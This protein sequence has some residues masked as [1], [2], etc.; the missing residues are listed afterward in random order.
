MSDAYDQLDTCNLPKSYNAKYG[1]NFVFYI[2]KTLWETIDQSKEVVVQ[3]FRQILPNLMKDRKVIAYGKC[4]RTSIC[5]LYRQITATVRPSR[6]YLN[7][8][9]LVSQDILR[10][11]DNM[12][13]NMLGSLA[14]FY[15]T[16]T[17]K[18]QIQIDQAMDSNY[19]NNL[20]A[21]SGIFPKCEV[22]FEGDKTRCVSDMSKYNFYVTGP[23]IKDAETY[24]RESLPGYS[25]G[26]SWKEKAIKMQEFEEL[27]LQYVS[28]DISGFD[29]SMDI[30]LK[31]ITH[32]AVYR[33]LKQNSPLY[34]HDNILFEA[35]CLTDWLTYVLDERHFVELGFK[36]KNDFR[37]RMLGQVQ[38]GKSCTAALNTIAL[39]FILTFI[40]IILLGLKKEQF[41]LS[42]SGDDNVNGIP[43]S[44][45]K[46]RIVE[47]YRKVF[48]PSFFYENNFIYPGM[49]Y[50]CGMQIK[51][52]VIGDIRTVKS[53]STHYTSCSHCKKITLYRDLEKFVRKISFKTA[54]N[55][56]NL[57]RL[58]AYKHQIYLANKSWISGLPLFTEINELLRTDVL[59][60]I[61]LTGETRKKK[62]MTQM[63][64]DYLNERFK[65]RIERE[66][67]LKRVLQDKNSIYTSLNE[68]QDISDCCRVEFLNDLKIK[69]GITEY[70]LEKIINKI[71]S[72][73]SED[74]HIQEL[75]DAFQ[76]YA[77]YMKEY[78]FIM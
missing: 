46:E 49:R 9:E 38:S 47:A 48:V 26:S 70:T 52:L 2:S 72:V 8:I 64:E 32:H 10:E 33:I 71:G 12:T 16:L 20:E 69:Y 3:N 58:N 30:E 74:I 27:S 18:Q 45:P 25:V 57:K 42:V 5:A 77:D 23:I 65:E 44:I 62:D 56:N 73:G 76:H 34:T 60:I 67:F 59:D 29:R 66:D 6:E 50:G 24:F 7:A 4:A 15:N 37:V 75:S 39:I 53:C 43:H 14:V 19:G 28:C 40:N 51:E 41:R 22:Q 68:N 11:I 55:I 21:R 17:Y 35:H 61:P 36:D 1:K 31:R 78:T 13:K 54:T 63:E